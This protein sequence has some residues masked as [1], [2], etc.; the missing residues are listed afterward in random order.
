LRRDK[1]DYWFLKHKWIGS[2]ASMEP[3]SK[4]PVYHG[5]SWG[6]NKTSPWNTSLSANPGS[7]TT[8]LRSHNVASTKTKWREITRDFVRSFETSIYRLERVSWWCFACMS[9][10]LT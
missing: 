10:K 6:N 2:L 9:A 3:I 5:L 7:S 1:I 4:I 8:F